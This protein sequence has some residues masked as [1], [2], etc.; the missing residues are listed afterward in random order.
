MIRF[1]ESVESP[2]P[3]KD[4]NRVTFFAKNYWF[5]KKFTFS[6][7]LVGFTGK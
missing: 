1:N 4:P 3:L 5:V 6:F 7:K 2:T